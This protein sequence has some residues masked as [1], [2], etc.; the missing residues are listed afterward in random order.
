MV[1]VGMEI[2]RGGAMLGCG[3]EV[4]LRWRFDGGS[5]GWRES[6]GLRCSLWCF[7]SLL[8]YSVGYICSNEEGKR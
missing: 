8:W 1:V 7:V 3:D 4:V 5:G 2:S 6:I